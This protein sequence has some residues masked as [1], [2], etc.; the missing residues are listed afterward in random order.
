MSY[1][2]SN[3]QMPLGVLIAASSNASASEANG[4][5]KATYLGKD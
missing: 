2:V 4:L 1:R 3:C 5:F